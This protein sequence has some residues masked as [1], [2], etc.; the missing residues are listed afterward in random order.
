MHLYRDV[1]LEASIHEG[2]PYQK[3]LFVGEILIRSL[4]A[5]TYKQEINT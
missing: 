3:L 5:S 4:G 1:L 2:F